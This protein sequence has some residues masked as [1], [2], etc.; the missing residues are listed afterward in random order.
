LA[1]VGSKWAQKLGLNGADDLNLELIAGLDG[2]SGY[3]SDGSR[4]ARGQLRAEL[5]W[6]FQQSS[7]SEFRFS[8]GAGTASSR[9]P[10]N[11]YFILGIGQDEPLPLR[12]HPTVD[13]GRKGNSPMGRKYLLANLELHRRLLSWSIF[14]FKGFLFSDSALVYRAPFGERGREWFQ[15]AGFGFRVG[16][17]G[18]DRVEVLFGFDLKESTFNLWVGIPFGRP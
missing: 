8:F 12:A 2:I 14:D 15:D 10:L 11:Q 1:L 4:S 16:T 7:R 17:L 6:Q 3:G 5:E 9:L 13:R 18:Q